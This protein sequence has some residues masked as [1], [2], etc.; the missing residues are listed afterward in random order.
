MIIHLA[1]ET[2]NLINKLETFYGNQNIQNTPSLQSPK[3]FVLDIIYILT[4]KMRCSR[5]YD[6]DEH[7]N[8]HSD[9]RTPAS[10][11]TYEQLS[12]LKEFM[13]KLKRIER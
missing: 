5:L 3:K 2:E 8:D 1:I 12:S 11:L 9:A 7:P 13:S 4:R 10:P 6:P